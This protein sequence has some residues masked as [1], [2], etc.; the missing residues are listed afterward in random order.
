M[1]VLP[2]SV[3][4]LTFSLNFEYP[5]LYVPR[6]WAVGCM[7][8]IVGFAFLNHD[9]LVL[10][11]Q[12]FESPIADYD[13]SDYYGD[14]LV[15]LTTMALLALFFVCMMCHGE[16][17]RQKPPSRYLTSFYMALATGGAIGGMGVALLCPLLFDS[18]IET[19]VMLALGLLLACYV[20][21][22]V[23]F[24]NGGF[25]SSRGKADVS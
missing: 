6:L 9:R 3:Y 17:V 8:A 23:V 25:S 20:P 7:A 11:D 21:V 22:S 13:W 10:M 4:L 24:A 15:L 5:R 18:F 16:L 14:H 1:W 12:W 2:L 19:K